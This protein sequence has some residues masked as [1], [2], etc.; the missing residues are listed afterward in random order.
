M[1]D[2]FIVE[3]HDL[4]KVYGDGEKVY[5][6]DGV[7]MHVEKGEIVAVMGPSGSGKS[8]LLHM[9]GALDRPTSGQVIVAGQDLAT[10]KRLDQFRN[11]TVGFIFQL[12]NLIP[13]LTAVENVEVPL[14]E[15]RIS[16]HQRRERAKE[17]LDLVGLGDRMK[18]LPGQL[19]GGQRQRVAIARAL[20]NRP[21]L[22]LADEPT[23]E[24]DSERTAEIIQT[25]HR[26]NQELGT[27]FVIVT[28]DPA[29]GR[30]TSRIIE[31]DSGRVLREHVVGEQ[32]D[33]DWKT[34]R[35]SPLGQALLNGGQKDLA[36]AGKPLYENGELT[37]TGRL[38]REMLSQTE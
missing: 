23:G 21:A 22:V 14:Y 9:I 30:E 17:L 7:T 19:S 27:T 16:S 5:A 31:L 28:H 10:V 33:E 1:N 11:R 24:L 15:Q 37:E 25:M 35:N 6:L 3:T 18:H 8:T 29:I 20:V 38:L 34:L 32:F 2:K 13:T 36:V 26:L 4:T 12:H